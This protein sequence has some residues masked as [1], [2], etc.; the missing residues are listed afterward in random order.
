DR[1]TFER[2]IAFVRTLPEP[3]ARAAL[4]FLVKQ[5]GVSSILVSMTRR[6]HLQENLLAVQECIEDHT[7]AATTALTASCT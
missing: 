4:S 6:R 5:P 1:S 7:T 3:P 2:A